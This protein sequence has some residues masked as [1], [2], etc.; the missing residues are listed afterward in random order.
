[1]AGKKLS[2]EES[3]QRNHERLVDAT[4]RILNREGMGGLTTGAIANLAGL[5]QPAFYLYFRSI[6]EAL[7]AAAE[8]VSIH[9]RS[10]TRAARL[11][12]TG[13]A[14]RDPV[15]ESYATAVKT[16]L[17]EPGLIALFVRH[18]KDR[19]TPLGRKLGKLE[20]EMHAELVADLGA[21]GVSRTI[22]DLEHFARLTTA[23]VLS[24]VEGLAD[25]RL[26]DIEASIDALTD[27]GIGAFLGLAAS[28]VGRDEWVE[29]SARLLRFTE[30]PRPASSRPRR[31]AGRPTRA[32][33]S[34]SSRSR[35][36]PRT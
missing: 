9:V 22:A 11:A 30:V 3:R 19:S 10:V 26:T 18:R 15:R 4:I 29:W 6:D 36:R 21:M 28:Q 32:P 23:S 17:E 25:K 24:T 34:P 7:I 33:G 16:W 31:G 35:S 2:R 5:S 12:A 27:A 1:V 14:A 8:K 20:A 13:L